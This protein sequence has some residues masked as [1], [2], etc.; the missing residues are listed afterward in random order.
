[1]NAFGYIYILKS[2][3]EKVYIGK[4]VQ[5]FEKYFYSEYKIKKGRN[6]TKLNR[7]INKYGIESFSKE[8]IL[9]CFSEEALNKAEIQLIKEYN[10]IEDGYNIMCGGQGGSHS[11]SSKVFSEEFAKRQSLS[12][13]EKKREIY[14]NNILNSNARMNHIIEVGKRNRGNKYAIGY[15]HSKEEC[16]RISERNQ[17]YKY[18]LLS[19][20]GVI[21]SITNLRQFC[22]DND[23]QQPNM[24]RRGYCKGWRLLS[25]TLLEAMPEIAIVVTS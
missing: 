2:P 10:S 17:I 8:V 5:D 23:L 3:S 19:P 15:K 4:T 24:C 7:A 1:M 9:T 13:D 16:L 14:R 6:R 18:D 22:K 12:F 20:D 11:P 21:H 25:K